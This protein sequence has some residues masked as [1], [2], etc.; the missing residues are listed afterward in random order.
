MIKAIKEFYRVLKN[1]GILILT[2]PAIN[3]LFGKHDKALHHFRRYSKRELENKIKE[4]GFKIEKISYWNIFLFPA[5]FLYRFFAKYIS[6]KKKSDLTP[7]FL[8]RP[9]LFVLMIE[10]KLIK[11][12]NFSYF[13][14]LG[15]S[16]I[17]VAR[18]IN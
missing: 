7:G 14:F 9:L 13:P 18:K 12:F 4:I 5:V 17:C 2:V 11:H 8:N 15:T 10:E 1:N 3:F 6:S 16:I